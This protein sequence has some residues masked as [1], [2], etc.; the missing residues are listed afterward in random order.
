VII[1]RFEQQHTPRRAGARRAASLVWLGV[2]T[3]ALGG[4]ATGGVAAP[5][6]ERLSAGQYAPTQTVDVLSA[7][8][9]M[10]FERIARLRLD[11]PTGVASESQLVA[12]LSEAAKNL[13]ANALVVGPV[14]RSGGADVAFNP[15][16]G[17]IQSVGTGGSISVTALAIR[18]TH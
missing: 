15:A 16:G 14:S 6:V 3:F 8:P 11:D 10:P 18:Y 9:S 2:L 12:Q 1:M 13:G 7:P 17:Q 5:S 4:C